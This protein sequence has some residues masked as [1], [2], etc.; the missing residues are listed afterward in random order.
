MDNLPINDIKV[1]NDVNDV[2]RGKN[3]SQTGQSVMFK[4]PSYSRTETRTERGT[5]PTYEDWSDIQGNESW[6][7]YAKKLGIAKPAEPVLDEEKQRRLTKWAMLNDIGQGFSTLAEAVGLH[8]GSSIRKHDIAQAP[9]LAQIEQNR[10]EYVEQ[11]NKYPKALQEYYKLAHDYELAR[12]NRYLKEIETQGTKISETT[13]S[14]G[15][16][17][18][19]KY[20]DKNYE[21]ALRKAGKTQINSTPTPFRHRIGNSDDF[22]EFYYTGKEDKVL[23]PA[24]DYVREKLNAKNKQLLPKA[25]FK[26]IEGAIRKKLNDKDGWTDADNIPLLTST[27]SWVKQYRMDLINE[28]YA[29][30][31]GKKTIDP[32]QPNSA[33]ATESILSKIKELDDFLNAVQKLKF[34]FSE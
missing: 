27:V 10:K 8:H 9:Q 20:T 12:K 21:I 22:F 28:Y 33:F 3:L 25:Y 34:N 26:N 4:E 15:S 18:T 16:S 24:A 2:N 19:N 1:N 5:Y 14:G 29:I 30:E 13:T 31:D 17:V 7:V 23:R 11:S 6:E 32:L